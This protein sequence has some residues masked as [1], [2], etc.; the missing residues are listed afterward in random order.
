MT[1]SRHAKNRSSRV[2]PIGGFLLVHVATLIEVCEQRDRKGLYAK[3]RA[4]LVKEFIGI[5][6]PYE[7]PAEAEVTLDTTELSPEEGA[8]EIILHLERGGLHWRKR[9]SGMIMRLV[10]TTEKLPPVVPCR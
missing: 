3:G 6:D 8:P 5:S 4:G 1:N 10:N 9:A 2:G 7:T